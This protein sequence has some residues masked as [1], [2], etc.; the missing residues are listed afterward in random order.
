MSSR[1]PGPTR[2]AAPL[3][4][5]FFTFLYA[6]V[7]CLL[8]TVA[9]SD[10]PYADWPIV[11]GGILSLMLLIYV[12]KRVVPEGI[13]DMSFL[14]LRERRDDPLVG[15]Q[16]KK[17]GKRR[18]ARYGTNKPPTAD[19]IRDIREQSSTTTWVPRDRSSN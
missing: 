2:Q 7:P 16:P 11:L 14:V 1:G 12:L 4:A 19:D 10:N 8:L 9:G 3:L 18:S 15:Y 6:L 13:N 5:T 17:R